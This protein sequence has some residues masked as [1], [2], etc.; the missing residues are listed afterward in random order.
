M[1]KSN[2]VT[3]ELTGDEIKDREYSEL[4]EREFVNVS[5][6]LKFDHTTVDLPEDQLPRGILMALDS[7]NFHVA[8]NNA[9]HMFGENFVSLSYTVI[10]KTVPQLA[11]K[12]VIK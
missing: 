10:N 11:K 5:V 4:Y 2:T 9:K 6:R 1:L 8:N 3:I 7:G 12:E